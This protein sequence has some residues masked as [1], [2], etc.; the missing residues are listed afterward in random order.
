MYKLYYYTRRKHKVEV[1]KLWRTF[2]SLVA[3]FHNGLIGGYQFKE[4]SRTLCCIHWNN[5]NSSSVRHVHPFQLDIGAGSFELW[6]SFALCYCHAIWSY[7]FHSDVIWRLF[8][9][10]IVIHYF[11]DCTATATPSVSQSFNN[12]CSLFF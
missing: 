1:C 8:T 3:D 7:R 12:F 2:K 10:H 5:L 9:K 11:W 4:N 6:P